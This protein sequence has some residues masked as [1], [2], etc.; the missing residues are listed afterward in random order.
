MR[1]AMTN[2]DDSSSLSSLVA[3]DRPIEQSSVF[4]VQ[5]KNN[6]DTNAVGFVPTGSDRGARVRSTTSPSNATSTAFED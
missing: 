6:A 5:T 3:N 1:S 2:L 4:C